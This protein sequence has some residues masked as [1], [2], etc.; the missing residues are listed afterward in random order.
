MQVK[1]RKQKVKRKS[2]TQS[3]TALTSQSADQTD[4]KL[5]TVEKDIAA[6]LLDISSLAASRHS[7]LKVSTIF[8]KT[9]LQIKIEK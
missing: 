7:I 4:T 1:K 3:V 8:N 6:S 2:K 9:S 5:L